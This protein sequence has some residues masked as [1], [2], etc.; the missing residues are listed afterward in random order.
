MLRITYRLPPRQHLTTDVPDRKR[1][2]GHGYDQTVSNSAFECSDVLRPAQLVP[3]CVTFNGSAGGSWRNSVTSVVKCSND[4]LML[5][6]FFQNGFLRFLALLRCNRGYSMAAGPAGTASNQARSRQC[7]EGGQTMCYWFRLWFVPVPNT[8][9]WSMT[10]RRRSQICAGQFKS[11]ET[12][13]RMNPYARWQTAKSGTSELNRLLSRL[14]RKPMSS[15]SIFG[16]A[17][18]LELLLRGVVDEI[19]MSKD[20]VR[21]PI[22]QRPRGHVSGNDAAP[23]TDNRPEIFTVKA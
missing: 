20:G 12:R 19:M 2:V 22:G 16:V 10:M 4:D 6:G 8:R 23:A 21:W 9:R 11:C 5:F 18:A 13:R 17:S 14:H 3:A 1:G 15:L 7:S